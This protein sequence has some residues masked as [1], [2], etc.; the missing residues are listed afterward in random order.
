MQYSTYETKGG[1]MGSNDK[2]DERASEKLTTLISQLGAD[3][4]AFLSPLVALFSARSQC[5]G[6]KARN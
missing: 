2:I 4:E 1:L 5:Y 3:S 6:Q